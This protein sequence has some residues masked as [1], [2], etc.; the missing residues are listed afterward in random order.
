MNTKVF[1][2]AARNAGQVAAVAAVIA[3]GVATFVTMRTSYHALVRSQA[4]Y[5][6]Q[7]RFADVFANLRRAPDSLAARIVAI[8]GVSAIETRLVY[9][10]TLDVPGLPEPA[11]G[12]LISL[13]TAFSSAVEPRLNRVY[14]RSGRA[15]HPGARNEVLASEAFAAANDLHPGDSIHGIL[16]GRWTRFL[17]AGIAISPEYV[18]ELQGA[19]F[20]PDNRRFGVFWMPRDS[21]AAAFGMTGAFND[22]SLRLAPGANQEEVISRLD[23]ILTRYGSPGAY[24]REDQLSHRFLSDEIRQD[25]VT[26]TVVPP[27]FLAIAAFL[28]HIVLTRLVAR[29]RDAIATLKAFGYSNAAISTHYVLFALLP[30]GLGSA[31]GVALGAWGGHALSRLYSDF[32]RFPHLDYRLDPNIVAV[33]VVIALVSAVAG[34]WLAV[35]SILR[36]QPAEA[37]RPPTPPAFH[38]GILERTGIAAAL[39]LTARFVIRN[40]ARHPLKAGVTVIGISLAIAILLVG[41]Y[42]YDS[43]SYLT[44]VQFAVVER[45]SA[46][47]TF[48]EIRSPSVVSSLANLPGVLRVEPFRFVPVRLRSGHRSYRTAIQGIPPSPRLHLLIDSNLRP[49]SLPPQGLVMNGTLA[50]I[51]RVRPG[52]RV[53]VEVLEGT[54]P[55]RSIRVAALVDELI[56][57]NVY[58][59]L[60][61]LHRMLGEAPAY[62]GA[63]LDADPVLSSSL[64][65]RLKAMPLI[66]G[67]NI[68]EAMIESFEKTIADSLLISVGILS[69]FAAVI[70]F[71]IVYNSVRIALSERSHELASLRVLGFTRREVAVILLGE[72]LFLSACAIPA[73]LAVGHLFCAALAKSLETELYRLPVVLSTRS[74]VYSLG[75]VAIAT[76]FSTILVARGVWRLDLIQALKTRE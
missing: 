60:P 5:Y 75:I 59:Q 73:G 71:S 8:P 40:L 65:S 56:G 76:L 39:P 34:A 67:V 13:P 19:A 42:F 44:H 58:A 52:D 48:P 47:V 38:T 18:Y 53:T 54:R 51:L 72:H 22:L 24:G 23:R 21:V 61:A 4:A 16:N 14:I 27:I 6:T 31:A 32:F 49:V 7:Y 20:F 45:Q 36:L 2:D 35:S 66:D 9:S 3:V 25:R 68:R 46:T 10:I 29:Q 43:L 63:W 57:T 17:I 50:R 33:G 55:V 62:S 70:A 11:S 15:P 1:R 64:Y 12:R 41:R 28:T 37:M 69:V 30:A 26:G 74:Y